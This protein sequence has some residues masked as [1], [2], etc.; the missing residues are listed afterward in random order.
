MSMKAKLNKLAP[1]KRNDYIDRIGEGQQNGTLV[2][3]DEYERAVIEKANGDYG[4]GLS[5]SIGGGVIGGLAA[6]LLV[7]SNPLGV[8]TALLVGLGGWKMTTDRREEIEQALAGNDWSHL[9]TDEQLDELRCLCIDMGK[10]A[11]PEAAESLALAH[12]FL[13][14]E[15]DQPVAKLLAPPPDYRQVVEALE[16]TARQVADE[17]T[18]LQKQAV[19]ALQPTHTA[20]AAREESP[21]A[22]MDSQALI[23]DG[24]PADAVP[25]LATGGDRYQISQMGAA[26]LGTPVSNVILP[27]AISRAESAVPKS[28]SLSEL[29]ERGE[30]NPNFLR[31]PMK[32]RAE[33]LLI[34]LA[35]AGCNLRPYL[36]TQLFK[37]NG[38][39]RSGKSTIHMI[40]MALKMALYPGKDFFFV[41]ADDDLYPL[42]FRA[43]FGGSQNNA[44]LGLYTM[45]GRIEAAGM[46]DLR[47]EVW[48]VDE[49]TR[50]INRAD[51]GNKDR[52]TACALYEVLL[53]GFKKSKGQ[54]HAIVHGTTC[55][56][57]GIPDGHAEAAK[58]E[59]RV[60]CAQAAY[61]EYGDPYP[62]GK[63]LTMKLNDTRFVKGDLA[64]TLPD[65]LLFKTN[66]NIIDEDYPGGHPPCYFHSFIEF[67]PEL[68]PRKSGSQPHFIEAGEVAEWDDRKRLSTLLNEHLAELGEAHIAEEITD[69][70]PIPDEAMTVIALAMSEEIIPEG[71]RTYRQVAE[72]IEKAF[73]RNPGTTEMTAW[74]IEQSIGSKYRAGVKNAIEVVVQSMIYDLHKGLIYNQE[75]QTISLDKSQPE[76]AQ[77]LAA[78][79][80]TGTADEPEKGVF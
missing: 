36:K 41:T 40:L 64:L 56:A 52:P 57:M 68:D 60:I 69:T 22:V 19:T 7:G 65:W 77:S 6:A 32:E 42:A 33:R 16:V 75:T 71:S 27:E 31:L 53:T 78:G 23:S 39:Q 20:T 18:Q 30:V 10:P 15:Y 59:M 38:P 47:D 13:E 29:F 79:T 4:A 61:T 74:E 66:P 34:A 17:Q 50:L 25:P 73:R 62:S 54:L 45:I 28:V 48:C 76:Y 37:T 8:G 58:N 1:D 70:S 2:V 72:D 5:L 55:K 49:M 43:V 21:I 26:P 24:A 46:N 80:G 9:L 44:A 11:T 35:Q 3:L 67:F 12:S 14:T 63:Y 51:R